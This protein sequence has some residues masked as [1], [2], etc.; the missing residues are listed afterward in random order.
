M[1]SLLW[2]RRLKRPTARVRLSALYACLFLLSGAVA[3]AIVYL[4]AAGHQSRMFP[5]APSRALVQAE[6]HA[7]LSH[8]LQASAL[9]LAIGTIG[10]ALLG[11]FAAGRALL[12]L[13][14]ITAAARTISATNLHAR[15]ALSGPEDEFKQLGDTLDDLLARLDR[16][17]EAQRRFVAHASHE[18]RTPL[19]VERTLLEVALADPDASNATLRATCEELLARGRDQERLLDALLTLASSERGLERREPVDLSRIAE[20]TLR[21]Q[22]P[23]IQRLG[24]HVDTMLEA[25]QTAGDEALLEQLIANLL[26]NA[27]R[28][29]VPE[30]Q[31]VVETG[32]KAGCAFVSVANTGPAVDPGMLERL[33]EAFQRGPSEITTPDGHGL[34]LSV[35]RAIATAHDAKLTAETRPAGGLAISATFRTAEAT[36]PG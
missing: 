13:R 6:R 24:L 15:L 9:V 27:A 23:S 21:A 32:T 7:D 11:W 25:A 36:R 12:P 30:G 20:R 8:L 28:Y 33:F 4:I 5:G 14:R 10:S 31:I 18:L 16:S 2:L 1:L 29:N 34:G 26:D 22:R 19:T 3:L 35:V 17:F